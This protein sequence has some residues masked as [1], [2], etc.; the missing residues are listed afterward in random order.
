[1]NYRRASTR[2]LIIKANFERTPT[3]ITLSPASSQRS[4][5]FQVKIEN[6]QNPL[7]AQG[8][9]NS[10]KENFQNET[11]VE[12][13]DSSMSVSSFSYSH[14]KSSSCPKKQKS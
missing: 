14:E 10:K 1:M 5:I 11:V 2:G 6:D 7:V 8:T 9:F 3:V 12:I 13:S 4:K